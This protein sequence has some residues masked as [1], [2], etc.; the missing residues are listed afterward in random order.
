MVENIT[1]DSRFEH[2]DV[3]IS[4]FEAA[5]RLEEVCGRP[6]CFVG[7][8]KRSLRQSSISPIRY[9]LVG[10]PPPTTHVLGADKWFY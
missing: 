10:P 2:I 5:F 3:N 7:R 8:C 4:L 9:S 1:L 6:R